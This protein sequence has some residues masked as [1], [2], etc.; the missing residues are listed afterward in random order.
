M[1]VFWASQT[2][3]TIH[4]WLVNTNLQGLIKNKDATDK[5]VLLSA[6]LKRYLSVNNEANTQGANECN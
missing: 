2:H 5:T 4:V 3:K 6:Y 1:V